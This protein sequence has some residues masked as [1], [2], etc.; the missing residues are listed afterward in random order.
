MRRRLEPGHFSTPGFPAPSRPASP[1]GLGKNGKN[2]RRAREALLTPGPACGCSLPTSRGLGFP[3][4]SLS[5]R[6]HS[7]SG[8]RPPSDVTPR[9]F[10]GCQRW[11]RLNGICS[12]ATG[13]S[14]AISFPLLPLQRQDELM[15]TAKQSLSLPHPS[16]RPF[17][18]PPSA[19]A[20]IP[21]P[22][23]PGRFPEPGEK[24]RERGSEWGALSQARDR[25]A[26]GS[27]RQRA[28]TK[29]EECGW[30]P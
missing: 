17:P 6:R 29:G 20:P 8:E 28:T 5:P 24:G 18:R 9:R 2:L 10:V 25:W 30:G 3:T 15:L 11:H 4:C 14:W 23:L 26:P 13:R 21:S 7:P 12:A 16:A 22:P 27:G 19:G 1:S